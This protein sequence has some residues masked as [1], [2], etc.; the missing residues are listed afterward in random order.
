MVSQAAKLSV[1]R[2]A[3]VIDYNDGRDSDRNV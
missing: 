1:K 3:I 2:S